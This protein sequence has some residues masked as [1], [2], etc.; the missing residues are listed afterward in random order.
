MSNYY[1]YKNLEVWK[2]AHAI[3]LKVY[4]S[5]SDFPKSEVYGLQSQIRRAAVSVP[6]NIVEGVSRSGNLEK[7]RFLNIAQASLAE[8]EYELILSQDLN[9]GDF[10]NVLQDIEILKKMLSSFY[11]SIKSKIDSVQN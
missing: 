6:A 5:T 10:Q 2:K 3:V 9:Y 4:D 1:S 8:L 7:L 11:G